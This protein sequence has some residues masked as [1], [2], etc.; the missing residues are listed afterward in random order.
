M[1]DTQAGAVILAAA[2][3]AAVPVGAV[4][5]VTLT[6]I[7]DGAVEVTVV[8]MDREVAATAGVTK[9]M[10]IITVTPTGVPTCI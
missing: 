3:L 2:A 10:I 6:V 9:E 1:E 5:V 8:V 7:P 4:E